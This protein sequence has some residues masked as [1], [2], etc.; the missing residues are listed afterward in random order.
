MAKKSELKPS[1]EKAG[2]ANAT[3]KV[4]KEKAGKLNATAKANKEK[5]G[6]TNATAKANKEKK[7]S[8]FNKIAKF[9]RDCVGEIKKITWPTPKS[10]FKNMGIVLAVIIVIG[11]FVFA[12]DM[13][14]VKL[15]GNFMGVAG[16]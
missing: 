11:L 7:L 3:A 5:A 14:L 6:K 10:T 4:S 16:S 12:L 9:F 2:K 8:F 13:G 15:L 1:S